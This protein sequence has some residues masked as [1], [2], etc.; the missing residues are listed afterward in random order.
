MN[1]PVPSVMAVALVPGDAV[2]VTPGS[3]LVPSVTVPETLFVSGTPSPEEPGRPCWPWTPCAP[4][5]P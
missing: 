5:G 1:A 3:A 4:W 2:T